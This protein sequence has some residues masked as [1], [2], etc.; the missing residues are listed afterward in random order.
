MFL[1]Q[2]GSDGLHLL[3]P[4]VIAIASLLFWRVALKIL[5][6]VLIVLV[7]SGAIHLLGVIHHVGG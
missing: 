6:I 4:V 3:A 1:V 7:I 5:A 2:G